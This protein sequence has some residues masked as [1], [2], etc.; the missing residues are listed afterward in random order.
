MK[1]LYVAIKRVRIIGLII[2]LFFRLK[3]RRII[4][5][6]CSQAWTSAASLSA[7]GD[8]RRRSFRKCGNALTGR[9]ARGHGASPQSR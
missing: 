5:I 9:L 4:K 1:I 2:A 6:I 7:L 3:K 8:A